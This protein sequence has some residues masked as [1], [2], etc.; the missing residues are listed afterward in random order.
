M[1]QQQ[2]ASLPPQQAQQLLLMLLAGGGASLGPAA[3]QALLSSLGLPHGAV[4]GPGPLPPVRTQPVMFFLC[5]S[6][7]R[8][9]LVQEVLLMNILVPM[10]MCAFL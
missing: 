1:L 4:A 6:R 10:Y 9:V 7:L 3:Q 8:H 5:F 2:L